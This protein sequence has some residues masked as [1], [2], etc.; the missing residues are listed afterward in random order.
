MKCKL[1]L[2]H[3]HLVVFTRV[4]ALWMRLTMNREVLWNSV[5][6]LIAERLRRLQLFFKLSGTAAILPGAALDN[7]KLR[8]SCLS[9]LENLWKVSACFSLG[10]SQDTLACKAA[11]C[12]ETYQVQNRSKRPGLKKLSFPGGKKKK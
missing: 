2:F 8:G 7:R 9:V 4:H 11:T 6:N 5:Q 12:L 3:Q 1:P 10:N